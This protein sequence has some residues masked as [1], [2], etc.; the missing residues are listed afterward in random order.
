MFFTLLLIC[1]QV[2]AQKIFINEGSNR[3]YNTIA[4]ENGEFPD[5]I[6]L[7]NPGP[8][9]ISL[10]NYRLSDRLNKPDMWRLP[11]I[12]LAPNEYKVIF[13]SGNN[14][15]P[16]TIFKPV[17]NTGTFTPVIGWNEHLFSD[18]I[19]WDGVSNLLINTCSYSNT[20]YTVNSVFNQSS[21]TY[22]SSSYTFNDGNEYSCGAPY[23]T[24]AKVRPNMR[25]NQVVIGNET[26]Q[27]SP[28]DYPA[29]YG[30]WY[31][32][33]R[34]QFLVRADELVAAGLTPGYITSLAFDVAWTDP[35]IVYTYVDFSLKLVQEAELSFEFQQITSQPNLH[36]NFKLSGEGD[37]VYLFNPDLELS[38]SLMVN[39]SNL[40]NSNGSFPDSSQNI[41]IFAPPT[42]GQ[43][44]NQSE[45]FLDYL[46]PPVI[47]TPAGLY[48]T[49]VTTII[50]NPNG[51]NSI[52]R[53]TLDGS[54]PDEN[55]P[56]F[57][58]TPITI[59]YSAVLKARAFE[60]GILPSKPVASSYLLGINHTTPILAVTTQQENLYGPNGIFDNWW[61]DWEKSAHVE[62]FDL[63]DTHRLII[64]QLAAMQM[65]GGA[66][67]SRFHPQHS[68]QINFAH[69]AL[70]DGSVEHA[71]I[72][73]KPKHITYD[74]IYLRNGS[75]QYLSYPYKDACA[76]EAMGHATNNYYSGWR[77]VSVYI[78]G[79]YFGLY[80]LREKFDT[81][82]FKAQ[83]DC[84][85]DSIDILSLSFWY[86][87]VLRAVEGSTDGFFT[88]MEAFD[89]LDPADSSF[90]EK[91]DRLFDMKYYHDYIIGESWV[92]N[93]D[94]PGNNIKIYRSD[95]TDFRWRYCIQDFELALEPGGWTSIYDDPI[96]FLLDIDIN[97]PYTRVWKR[98]MDNP[99]FRNYFINR[100]A[101]LMNT[102][103]LPDSLTQVE[104]RMFEQTVVEMP[105]LYARWGNPNDIPGQMNAFNNNHLTYQFS[106][107]ARSPEVRNFIQSNL[108]LNGQVEVILDAIPAGAGRITLNTITPG[109]LP[110]SG[111]YFDGNEI[112]LTAIPEPG[113][114]F[115]YWDTNEVLLNIDTHA[116]LVVNA[117]TS[118]LFRAVFAP[119]G[120]QG[121]MAFSELHYHPDSTR[122][123]DDW[124]E[125]LNYGNGA[126]DISGWRLTDGNPLNNFT[127]P[128]G[129]VVPP[130]GRL[131]LAQD[132]AR[133]HSQH[134]QVPVW[135]P[136]GLG[137][138]NNGETISLYNRFDELVLQMTYDNNEPWPLVANGWGPSLELRADSLD[139]NLPES[140][141]PGCIGGS[142]GTAYS[143]C[144]EA[145]IFSEINYA[146]AQ[147]A[148]AE[149]WVELYNQSNQPVDL[150]NWI[151][152]DA[153]EDNTYILPDLTVLNPAEY[154]V[155]YRNQALFA[156]SYPTVTN[157]SGPFSFGLSNSGDALRLYD[158]DGRLY[159]SVY[160]GTE[161]PWPVGANG[162]GYTLELIDSIGNPN[163]PTSW[164]DGCLQGSPGGPLVPCET[165]STNQ[166]TSQNT[167]SLFPNP[168]NGQFL[169]EV[170]E[171][172]LDVLYDL[173]VWNTQ[174]VLL[175]QLNGLRNKSKLDLRALPNGIYWIQVVQGNRSWNGRLIIIP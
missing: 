19:Y 76:V 70:G 133:F 68:F 149:D 8:D 36:T 109:P 18:S 92:G 121:R 62:Y 135:G 172:D 10:L 17:H 26:I 30:N 74:K 141:F 128:L 119:T 98:G 58:G 134:P 145:I 28:Y 29:P 136:I 175:H 147:D 84:D 80:E 46:L 60:A 117:H 103:Y 91:T 159:Q 142:P 143:P 124:I 53:Y 163:L 153:A 144:T 167:I 122:N 110:W 7:F 14:R 59:F 57:D 108:G 56:V 73:T 148:N 38:S 12:P 77:P 116:T 54:D 16:I 113:Y 107:T 93:R 171:I 100:F 150:S 174:G 97:N 50:T 155:L 81:E 168:N 138:S 61:T 89:I 23:G 35:N 170:P 42:P 88:A 115:L 173:T 75:N 51:G 161:S 3:N 9:T 164:K 96:R 6:E 20:G 130:Q 69:S 43:S 71:F 41:V 111:I 48:N 106:L 4:D 104:Q 129:T 94:W 27:N 39:S 157:I 37:T 118:T 67:G 78:N 24:R 112:S 55:D 137:F 44:N 169:L 15:T 85:K 34:H 125:L 49:I 140:W 40:D 114:T 132:T 166:P 131:V 11:S 47:Q 123:S 139:P 45:T 79:N 66:G 65:D 31:W 13:C 83:D 82:F 21:T 86:N 63:Q 126:L 162:N 1:T 102:A 120:F 22:F 156:L 165:S 90:W 127:F 87:S 95:K 154:L 101:D 146:S 52:V 158:A 152:K 99:K 105:K 32:T 33:A 2:S 25:I 151:F 72:P 5:W 160:Y 64:S